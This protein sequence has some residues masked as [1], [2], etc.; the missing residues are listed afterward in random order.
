MVAHLEAG[1]ARTNFFD[2]AGPLEHTRHQTAAVW[3]DILAGGPRKPQGG[4]A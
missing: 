2:N 1:N 3:R 4:A